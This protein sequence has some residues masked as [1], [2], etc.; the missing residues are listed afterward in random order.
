MGGGGDQVVDIDQDGKLSQDPS[1]QAE[2]S[3]G[4]VAGAKKAS[5]C[6]R[7]R[8]SSLTGSCGKL[9]SPLAKEQR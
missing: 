9:V 1:A 6:L 5:S 2:K 7:T 4:R 3:Q 8:R